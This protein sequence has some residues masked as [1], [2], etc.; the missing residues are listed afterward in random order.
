MRKVRF[1][2]I[3]ALAVFDVDEAVGQFYLAPNVGFKSY[4]LKGAT[5]VAVG[6]RIIPL[7]IFDGGKTSFNV[8]VGVGFPILKIPSGIYRMDMRDM[9][10]RSTYIH[11]IM[12]GA[13]I[14]VYLLLLFW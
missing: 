12:R 8:A 2:L 3:A 11:H 5:T 4:G 6:G 14:C 1:F 9:P 10:W 13:S 7:G